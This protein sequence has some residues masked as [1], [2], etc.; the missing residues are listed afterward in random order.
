VLY[1]TIDISRVADE[2]IN[3]TTAGAIRAIVEKEIR[4]MEG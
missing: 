3:K 4:A 2:D 1:Y